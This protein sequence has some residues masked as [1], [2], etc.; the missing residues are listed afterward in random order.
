M[1][2]KTIL[3]LGIAT[4]FSAF[5]AIATGDPEQPADGQVISREA[6]EGPRGGDHECPGE[7]H[8]RGGRLF[9]CVSAG[10]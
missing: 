9:E 1:N 10:V 4:A 3:M 6:S 5:A 7:L 8:R 2:R